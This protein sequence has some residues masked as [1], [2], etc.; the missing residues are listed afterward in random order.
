MLTPLHPFLRLL[1][2]ISMDDEGGEGE[3]GDEYE[4]LRGVMQEWIGVE[5]GEVLSPMGRTG[6]QA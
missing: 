2:V 3:E 6:T 1:S 5:A 4:R